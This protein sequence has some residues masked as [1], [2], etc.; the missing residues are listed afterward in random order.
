MCL[1]FQL[2]YSKLAISAIS[3]TQNIGLKLEGIGIGPP[4][5]CEKRRTELADNFLPI[6]DVRTAVVLVS[7]S[8]VSVWTPKRREKRSP[9]KSVYFLQSF[10]K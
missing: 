7:A 6:A 2:N 5:M 3:S 8:E 4:K 10:R 9:V 1:D